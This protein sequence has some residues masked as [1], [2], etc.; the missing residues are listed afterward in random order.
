MDAQGTQIV[1]DRADRRPLSI[2]VPTRDRPEMLARCLKSVAASMGP[3]DELIVVDSASRDPAPVE[4]TAT[5]LGARFL[6]SE[7]PGATRARNIGWRAAANDLIGFIDDDVWVDPGWANAIVER[8]TSASDVEFLTGRIEAPEGQTSYYV[9]I[10]D[11]PDPAVFDRTTKGLTGHSASMAAR[12]SALETVGGFDVWMGPGARFRGADDGDLFDRL[13]LQGYLCAYEPSALAWHDQWRE[14]AGLVRLNFHSGVGAGGRL[15]KLLRT[16][17]RRLIVV[18]REYWQW[19]AK[20][21]WN[22]LQHR[23]KIV[24]A[25]AAVRSAGIVAGFATGLT[26]RIEK[27]H[28]QGRRSQSEPGC[29][30]DPSPSRSAR[31]AQP[32]GYPKH[33]KRAGNGSRPAN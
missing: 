8:L 20:D 4:R 5:A 32:G 6:R 15:A 23:N 17:T 19:C 13:F 28:Y 27:G 30:K 18:T 31:P 29:G 10:K 2:V 14:K 9:A 25:S 3:M 33:A 26:M 24:L 1:E 11:D 7:L 21:A 16:D 22:G 12:R